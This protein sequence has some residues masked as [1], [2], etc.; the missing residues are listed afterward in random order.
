M[1]TNAFSHIPSAV[2]S[3]FDTIG[4][5]E[6]TLARTY[7]KLSEAFHA[8]KIT[9]ADGKLCLGMALAHH[10]PEYKSQYIRT[11]DFAG[12]A[13]DGSLIRKVSRDW[14]TKVEGQVANSTAPATVRVP[15]DLQDAINA[16]AAEYTPKQ[17]TA[18]IKRAPKQAK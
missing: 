4:L 15:R 13:R 5:A 12:I 8:G 16:L 10:V 17:I 18:A 14:A 11:K 2:L 7:S 1:N 3:M 6:A 9:K